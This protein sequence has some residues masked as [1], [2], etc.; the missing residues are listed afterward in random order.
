MIFLNIF[1]SP[2]LKDELFAQ[3]YKQTNNCPEFKYPLNP[4]SEILLRGLK[5][6]FLA[7]KSFAPSKE[8]SNTLLS[9][10]AS[11]VNLE[12]AK[13]SKCNFATSDNSAL[14][15]Y[16]LLENLPGEPRGAV[17]L[18]EIRAVTVSSCVY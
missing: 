2:I 14:C 13:C 6:L 10:L 11:I 15:C 9:H 1:K 5:L 3:L 18:A 12:S 7:L 8:M 4:N 16:L 17:S